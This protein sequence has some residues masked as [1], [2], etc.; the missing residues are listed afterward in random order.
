MAK[1]CK[2]TKT[3]FQK[4]IVTQIN[5]WMRKV[6]EAMGDPESWAYAVKQIYLEIVKNQTKSVKDFQGNTSTAAQ[7]FME[8]VASITD[9]MQLGII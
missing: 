5:K 2:G 6:P 1:V 7:I 8:N 3:D 9:P 4:K